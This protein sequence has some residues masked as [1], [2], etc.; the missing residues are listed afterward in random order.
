MNDEVI[1]YPACLRSGVAA[2][3][4]LGD[5][6][7]GINTLASYHQVQLAQLSQMYDNQKV[8]KSSKKSYTPAGGGRVVVGVEGVGEEEGEEDNK[9]TYQ[10]GS[11]HSFPIS[12]LSFT[13]IPPPPKG[14]TV[15]CML[16]QLRSYHSDLLSHVNC[17][18]AY[19]TTPTTSSY[20]ST[21]L[22]CCKRVSSCSGGRVSIARPIS[23]EFIAYLYTCLSNLKLH[24]V[25]G[26]NWRKAESARKQRQASQAAALATAGRGGGGGGGDD[27]YNSIPLQ[28]NNKEIGIQRRHSS[29]SEA[30]TATN[31]NN[32]NIS[33]SSSTGHNSDPHPLPVSLGSSPSSGTD[34]LFKTNSSVYDS[35][36]SSSRLKGG[37]PLPLN[38]NTLDSDDDNDSIYEVNLNNNNNNNTNTNSKSPLKKGNSFETHTKHQLQTFSINDNDLHP[39]EKLWLIV[40]RLNFHMGNLLGHAY[41]GGYDTFR[42]WVCN[43]MVWN[44]QYID[45]IHNNTT[46][47]MNSNNYSNIYS[48]DIVHLNMSI[49]EYLNLYDKVRMTHLNTTSFPTTSS[50]STNQHP[51]TSSNNLFKTDLNT[52]YNTTSSD[53]GVYANI[54]FIYDAFI[55]IHEYIIASKQIQSVINLTSEEI[56][57]KHI[58]LH[59]QSVCKKCCT[60]SSS[61]SS[62]ACCCLNHCTCGMLTIL[63]NTT[64]NTQYNTP[65]MTTPL[66]N[67]S[68]N[69]HMNP[70]H[71]PTH[72]HTTST[73]TP[74][75][76]LLNP[77]GPADTTGNVQL[78]GNIPLT[79]PGNVLIQPLHHPSTGILGR[80]VSMSCGHG[81]WPSEGELEGLRVEMRRAGFDV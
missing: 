70:M 63:S 49:T 62:S 58:L 10:E 54:D 78:T 5:N 4:T 43:S 25:R 27:R 69:T 19:T 52:T 59:E 17:D 3:L 42:I 56:M 51:L 28:T 67:L 40:I 20:C 34:S 50:P 46:N 2:Y 21:V 39:F 45:H 23:E 72:T 57:Y 38:S 6:L 29:R 31:N 66:V 65:N 61:S 8:R 24:A 71:T 48:S 73:N 75:Q 37:A 13:S 16:G 32:K 15:R 60:T 26:H 14:K 22:R 12:S 80:T 53:Q 9:L 47:T 79:G 81:G 44:Q 7:Y 64:T 11:V 1:A 55:A 30:H 36:S 68:E 35:D 77:T 74:Y 33:R 76:Q 41:I 18:S